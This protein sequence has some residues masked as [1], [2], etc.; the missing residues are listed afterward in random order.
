MYQLAFNSLKQALS[1]A[2]VLQV[3]DFKKEFFLATD[4]NDLAIS[5]VS[6]QRVGE[7]L[8][9]FFIIVMNPNFEKKKYDQKIMQNQE[10]WK[11]SRLTQ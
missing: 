7:E 6:N 4:S 9:Q 2:P 11:A 3:P 1:E 5:V 8:A 10:D